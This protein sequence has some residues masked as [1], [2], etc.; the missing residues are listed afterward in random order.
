MF[1]II[2][3]YLCFVSK[4]ISITILSLL[5]EHIVYILKV[6][7]DV[8]EE[9]DI[10]KDKKVKVEIEKDNEIEMVERSKSKFLHENVPWN[11]MDINHQEF[12]IRSQIIKVL[13]AK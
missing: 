10:E 12:K 7:S 3:P 1:S 8:H 9:K 5:S 11:D 4:S 2:D 6:E 13:V